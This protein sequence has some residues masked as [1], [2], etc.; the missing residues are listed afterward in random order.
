MKVRWLFHY[1]SY[2]KFDICIFYL[3]DAKMCKYSLK[4]E[5]GRERIIFFKLKRNVK[6]TNESAKRT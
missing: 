2:G 5:S 4:A 3:E 1:K 6:I